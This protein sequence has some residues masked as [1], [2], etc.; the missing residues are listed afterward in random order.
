[1]DIHTDQTLIFNTALKDLTD[2]ISKKKID[3][4]V[5]A[6]NLAYVL[7]RNKTPYYYKMGADMAFLGYGLM[8]VLNFREVRIEKAVIAGTNQ[9]INLTEKFPLCIGFWRPNLK[10]QAERRKRGQKYLIELA[11]FGIFFNRIRKKEIFHLGH[12]TI[13]D[14]F[15]IKYDIVDYKCIYGIESCIQTNKINKIDTQ[16]YVDFFT[17]KATNDGKFDYVELEKLAC[18]LIKDVKIKIK[19]NL[20]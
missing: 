2:R 9:E 12:F 8:E 4:D 1:M 19:L 15:G 14:T 17:K 3:I 10:A 13:L 7:L 20:D 6:K 11:N 18:S 5:P 16:S